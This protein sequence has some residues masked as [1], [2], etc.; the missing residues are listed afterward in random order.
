MHFC[1]DFETVN[2]TVVVDGVDE[3]DSYMCVVVRH[4]HDVKE[5]LA[6]R[7]QLPQ[8][9]VHGLQSLNQQIEEV[10]TK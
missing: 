10:R 6:L 4:Q 8:T 1:K 5:L 9:V 3:P 2:L 7:V